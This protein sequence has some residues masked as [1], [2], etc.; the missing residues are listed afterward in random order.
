MYLIVKNFG[1]WSE[2]MIII[3]MIIVFGFKILIDMME[4][5]FRHYFSYHEKILFDSR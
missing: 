5:S 4:L 3:N 1:L 2:S